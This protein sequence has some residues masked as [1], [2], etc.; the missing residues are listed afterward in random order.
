MILSGNM[1]EIMARVDQS[2][3][4]M[5]HVHRN[6]DKAMAILRSHGCVR[7][8][9]IKDNCLSVGFTGDAQ[10]E[11][12]LLQRL[13]DAEVLIRG[14]YRQQGSLE[15]LFMQITDH[16]DKEVLLYEGKPSI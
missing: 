11:V 1:K 14:F 7:T 4:L 12:L 5:I 15:S 13:I 3:P 2:N 8:I 16:K 10:D 9:S 6:M